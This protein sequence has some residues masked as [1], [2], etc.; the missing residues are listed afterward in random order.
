[1]AIGVSY[2]MGWQKRGKAHNSLTGTLQI[3]YLKELKG[4]HLDIV[5]I[6]SWC[7]FLAW[8]GRGGGPLKL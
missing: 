5:F 2:D 8:G 7:C 6:E 3:V 4:V 1:M